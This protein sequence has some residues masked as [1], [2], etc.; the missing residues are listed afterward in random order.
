MIPEMAYNSPLSST[1][2]QRLIEVIASDA[3]QRVIDVGCGRGTLLCQI[4][5]AT[6]AQGVGIDID[7]TAIAAAR[8]KAAQQNLSD[9]CRFD[10]VD[11]Q[12]AARLD[13]GFDLALCIGSTHAFAMG[14]GAFE[15]A[16]RG[17]RALVRPGGCLLIGEGYW[18]Q[19]PADAYLA[20][21]G[22]TPGVYRSHAENVSFAEAQGLI[23][24]YALVSNQDEW[25]DFEWSHRLRTERLAARHPD[26]PRWAERRA[27]SRRWREGYL[28][29][30]RSTMGF[31]WYL[32][33]VPGGSFP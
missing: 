33:Q 25:D 9:R 12:S 30:G 31:G 5:A 17:L 26:D 27:R 23:P 29:W 6:G 10:V 22:D 2:A 11:I 13:D 4:I 18:K 3:P 19:T 8:H 21:L 14:S 20:L 7:A 16:L 1:K 24:L 15:A 32:F 28:R